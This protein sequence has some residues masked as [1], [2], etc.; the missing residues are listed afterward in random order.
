MTL[1]VKE[2]NENSV[3]GFIQAQFFHSN[4]S[5]YIEFTNFTST[6]IDFCRILQYYSIHNI[7]NPYSKNNLHS[8]KKL[9]KINCL[10]NNYCLL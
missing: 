4:I 10:D 5:F 6:K 9:K 2:E 3:F 1:N 8:E 7:Q